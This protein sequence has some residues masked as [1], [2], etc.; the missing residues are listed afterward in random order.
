MLP[1][2]LGREIRFPNLPVYLIYIDVIRE[3][4]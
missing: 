1:C 2:W 3:P 4:G